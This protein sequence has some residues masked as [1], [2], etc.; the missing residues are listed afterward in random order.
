MSPLFRLPAGRRRAAADVRDE[1]RLHLELCEADLVAAGLAPEA[2]RAEALRRF[3][4]PGATAAAC[5]A[6]EGGRQARLAWRDRLGAF[7]QDL[8]YAA[9]TLRRAPG[10]TLLVVLTLG[11]GAGATAAMFSVVDAVL[12]RPLPLPAPERVVA[13]VPE[14]GGEARGGSPGLLTAWGARGRTRRAVGLAVAAICAASFVWAL[15]GVR[16]DLA[17]TYFS[18]P[19][20]AWELGLGALAA[21]GV[22]RLRRL[23]PDLLAAVSWAGLAMVGWA[24]LRFTGQTPVPGAPTLLPV[25]GTALLLGGGTAAA[26]WGPQGLLSLAPARWVGDRSYSLYLWHWPA[27]VL[28]G[29]TWRTPSGWSGVAVA[30]GALVLADLTYRLVENPFRTAAWLRPRWRGV[31]L[32][33]VSVAALALVVGAAQWSVVRDYSQERPAVTVAAYG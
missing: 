25:V 27:L 18:T 15:A 1:I 6:I 33:P 2:A 22:G 20:R 31:A 11:L 3:G 12:L 5:L 13:L 24:A 14:A 19:A 9:R 32:Y 10:F 4:D 30:L 16:T 23:S 8:A 26:A 17:A 21:T 28:V 7:G 29:A